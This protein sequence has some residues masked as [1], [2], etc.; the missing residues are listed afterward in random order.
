M[1]II[2]ATGHGIPPLLYWAVLAHS[3]PWHPLI[4]SWV[5]PS[6]TITIQFK[7]W[8]E[9]LQYFISSQFEREN[10]LILDAANPDIHRRLWALRA[11]FGQ[12]CMLI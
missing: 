6:M 12:W 9:L 11:C 3:D 7:R 1:E 2:C 5:A 4:Q 8:V 10:T